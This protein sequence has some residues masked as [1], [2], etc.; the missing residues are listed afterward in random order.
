MKEPTNFTDV[1]NKISDL[2]GLFQFG[3]KIVPIFQDLVEFMKDVVPLMENV[4]KSI[5]ES[6][7]KMP[8]AANQ[9]KSVTNATELATTE[10]LDRVDSISKALF[11][12][13]KEMGEI[14]DKRKEKEKISQ[15][16]QREINFTDDQKILLSQLYEK[17]NIDELLSDIN[18]KLS[19]LNDESYQITLA[20][21]VQD[22]TTQQ[23]AAVNH[24]IE[25]VNDKLS[26]LVDDIHKAELDDK[27][28]DEIEV[29]DTATFDP[30]ARYDKDETRQQNVDDII[31][32][33]NKNNE[34]ASQDEIDKLFS[35][36]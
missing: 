13:E 1:F 28:V 25:S 31:E 32:E 6:T 9:I 17:D 12:I 8:S 34:I 30:N 20:L 29:P 2:K 33:E 18:D 4:N 19:I 22:I 10:I 14:R 3:E 7:N 11:E 5:A 24:L 23:L 26:S 27:K 16:L 21:Q 15:E 35:G 36:E